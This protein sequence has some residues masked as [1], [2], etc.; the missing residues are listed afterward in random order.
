MMHCD[1]HYCFVFF[2]F[3]SSSLKPQVPDPGSISAKV[4]P[5]TSWIGTKRFEKAR[6]FRLQ[7]K[8]SFVFKTETAEAFL[9]IRL[10]H[11]LH[12]HF[13]RF[14]IIELRGFSPLANYTDRAIAAGQRS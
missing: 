3:V 9:P 4:R 8:Y 6:F 11:A 2:S 14:I 5:V 12:R 7:E 10:Y 1:I 13:L